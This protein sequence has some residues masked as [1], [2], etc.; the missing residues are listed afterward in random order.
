MICYF[1]GISFG[2]NF[3]LIVLFWLGWEV[4]R[5]LKNKIKLI[6]IFFFLIVDGLV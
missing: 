1:L 3:I 4:V 2:L 6:D 5:G